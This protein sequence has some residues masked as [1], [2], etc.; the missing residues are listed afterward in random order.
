MAYV[1]H[2]RDIETYISR[3]IREEV[4]WATNELFELL[5]IYQLVSYTT[6]K[7]KNEPV[8]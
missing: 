5:I 3:H 7:V 8:K 1:R 6:M 4:T 2:I